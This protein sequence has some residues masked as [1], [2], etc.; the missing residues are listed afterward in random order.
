MQITE[1]PVKSGLSSKD[2][3]YLLW[4]DIQREGSCSL[5]SA[6]SLCH[7]GL[8]VF[9]P[10][11]VNLFM[12]PHVATRC[13]PHFEQHMWAWQRLAKEGHFLSVSIFTV[14]KIFSRR[15]STDFSLVLLVKI[16]SYSMPQVRGKLGGKMS[17]W[18]CLFVCFL[19]SMVESGLWQ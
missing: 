1:H 8:G 12:G 6:A 18:F 9:L 19:A 10:C 16:G 3:Y 4:Q 17:I 13:L 2:I 5:G 11:N 7:P 15:L 14:E